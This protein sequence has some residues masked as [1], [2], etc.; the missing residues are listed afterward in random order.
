MTGPARLVIGTRGSGLALTQSNW[1][2]NRL[3]EA[4]PGQVEITLKIIKTTGDRIQGE[5]GALPPDSKGLFT[6]ELE[7]E[8]AAGSIDL[9]VHSCKDLPTTLPEGFAIAAV[10][11]RESPCDV[12]LVPKGES[13][14]AVME[15]G[16]ILTG[17]PRRR[18]QWLD[19]YPR[20]VMGDIRGN[21]DTRIRKLLERGPGHVL[22]L[23]EAGLNRLHPD[24]SEVDMRPL[25]FDWM[26]P[27]PGQGALALECRA[28]DEATLAWCR[29]LEH[30]P[31]HDAVGAERH[32][33]AA[34]GGGCQAPVAALAEPVA[35]DRLRLRV[36]ALRNGVVVRTEAEGPLADV[37]SWVDELAGKVKT[38]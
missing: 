25:D 38:A 31:S 1:V 20:A 9:A 28:G 8:L 29:P 32:F 36:A 19:R 17:S 2:K 24:L 21:I 37:A 3:E 13:L 7:V 30:G 14:D 12:A 4:W 18:V 10:P 11:R 5:S 35:S 23:A 15:A 33:L 6:K 34:M 26:L 22:V 27:A 16:T